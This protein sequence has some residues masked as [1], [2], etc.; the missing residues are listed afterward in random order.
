MRERLLPL[1]VLVALSGCGAPGVDPSLLVGA[2]RELWRLRAGRVLERRPLDARGDADDGLLLDSAPLGAPVMRLAL[3]PPSLV[4]PPEREALAPLPGDAV[5]PGAVIELR[6]PD[7]RVGTHLVGVDP[8]RLPDGSV[9]LLDERGDGIQ[10]F[11][12]HVSVLVDGRVVDTREVRVNQPLA[13]GDLH[14]YQ[15]NYRRDDLAWSGFLVVDDPGL[16]VVFVGMTMMVLGSA[17]R[18]IAKEVDE[19]SG[20]A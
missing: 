13:W 8:I 4:P 18:A 11:I 5:D 3:R 10:A 20:S 9:L 17:G 16:D 6:G 12:S 15:Q 14:I 1:S 19:A 2:T 7:G